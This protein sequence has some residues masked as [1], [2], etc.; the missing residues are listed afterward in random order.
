MTTKLRSNRGS[1]KI[2]S[3]GDGRVIA[4]LPSKASN[5]LLVIAP[6][7]SRKFGRMCERAV[8]SKPPVAG[9]EPAAPEGE[10]ACNRARDNS[11]VFLNPNSWKG[12]EPVPSKEG[13]G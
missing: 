6:I 4:V 2:G 5:T 3:F 8:G 12:L 13:S 10:R 7:V 11:G 1:S 9:V